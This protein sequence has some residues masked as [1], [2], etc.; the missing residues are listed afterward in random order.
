MPS[1]RRVG[2][3]PPPSSLTRPELFTTLERALDQGRIAEAAATAEE[4]GTPRDDDETV[5]GA[6]ARARIA[7]ARGEATEA[8]RILDL[9]RAKAEG[10]KHERAWGLGRAR[11][12]L[13]RG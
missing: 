3:M 6:L 4:I 9:V 5:R 12:A 11:A 2:T 8:G 1:S 10:T 13:R 7:V